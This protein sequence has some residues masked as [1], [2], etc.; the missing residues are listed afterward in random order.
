MAGEAP[1]L[2]APTSRL[3]SPIYGTYAGVMFP[4]F[5][6]AVGYRELGEA[7]AK[8]VASDVSA[9]SSCYH[10][11]RPAGLALYEALPYLLFSDPVDRSYFS[12]LL[13]LL[14]LGMAMLLL[15]RVFTSETPAPQQ[16]FVMVAVVAALLLNLVPHVPMTLADLPALALFIGAIHQSTR[17]FRGHQNGYVFAGLFVA[18]A[19]HFK[20]TYLAH[21][22]FLIC[23]TLLFDP[24][25]FNLRD[26]TVAALKF[27][28]GA[29]PIL[30]QVGWIYAHSGEPWFYEKKAMVPFAH[31]PKMPNI[32][33]SFTTLPELS[34]FMV[35]A[36]NDISF[37]TFLALK[38]SRALT[39]FEWA[40]YG[41]YVKLS[42]SWVVTSGDVT[43]AWL[44]VL[45][46]FALC[47]FTIIRGPRVLRFVN[48]LALAMTLFIVFVAHV[49]LRFHI[50][51]RVAM[52]GTIAFWISSLIWQRPRQWRGAPWRGAL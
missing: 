6:D 9:W 46:Y 32:E 36:A 2:Q 39:G 5:G 38:M 48:A 47:A 18:A 52:W 29:L 17:V 42:R 43:K 20:Q 51:S 49:E 25:R 30:L 37:P 35:K 41:G 44:V 23:A 40:V 14:W 33:A 3:K 8:G 4:S 50:F 22:F 26:R 31:S 16:R 21:G 7:C 19:F 12:L 27:G 11:L 34:A 10:S 28:L 13:N 15:T 45:G 24:A 1:A